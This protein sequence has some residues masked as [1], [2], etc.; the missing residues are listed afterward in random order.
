MVCRKDLIERVSDLLKR[1]NLSCSTAVSR[2]PE[3]CD[4]LPRVSVEA[5]RRA[6]WWAEELPP[7]DT[8]PRELWATGPRTFFLVR[9]HHL[10]MVLVETRFDSQ[11]ELLQHVRSQETLQAL[12]S[13]LVLPLYYYDLEK[14]ENLVLGLVYHLEDWEAGLDSL[15]GEDQLQAMADLQG[16][17]A[18]LHGLGHCNIRI[19]EDQLFFGRGL[20]VLGLDINSNSPYLPLLHA[21]QATRVDLWEVLCWDP[22]SNDRLELSRVCLGLGLGTRLTEYE[23]VRMLGRSQVRLSPQHCLHSLLEEL[24]PPVH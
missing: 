21:Y 1:D 20:R 2:Q 15:R 3:P 13:G 19:P 23:F 11:D 14:V 18:L 8:G 16:L 10:D 22:A 17:V 7:V 5:V 24:L 6:L 4:S 9:V 12:R